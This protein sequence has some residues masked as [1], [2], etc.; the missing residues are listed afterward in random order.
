M[1]PYSP[2]RTGV[3]FQGLPPS[4][5]PAGAPFSQDDTPDLRVRGTHRP[6][7]GGGW[8]GWG[9]GA[10]SPR[11][12]HGSTGMSTPTPRY[13]PHPLRAPVPPG[14]HGSLRGTPSVPRGL[15][16]SVRITF[17]IGVG[18][19]GPGAVYYGTGTGIVPVKLQH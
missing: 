1:S 11:G 7:G 4:L 3:V 16:P 8:C 19:P 17:P 6:E 13:H 10:G 9:S 18:P 15:G 5:A 12:I 14:T 2:P